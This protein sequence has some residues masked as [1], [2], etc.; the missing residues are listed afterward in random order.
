MLGSLMKVAL[1]FQKQYKPG[2]LSI[3]S[4][5]SRGMASL[6]DEL[7]PIIFDFA[8]RAQGRIGSKQANSLSRVSRRFRNIALAERSL[9]TTLRSNASKE[10]LQTFISRSGADLDFQVFVDV[11]PEW[12]LKNRDAFWDELR[13]TASRWKTL[14]VAE[15]VGRLREDG[16]PCFQLYEFFRA[17]EGMQLLRLQELFIKAEDCET[18]YRIPIAWT[19][20]N[21]RSLRCSN[22]TPL[23][24]SSTVFSSVTTCSLSLELSE[25]E[26]HFNSA[27]A[28]LKSLLFLPS[29]TDMELEL[30]HVADIGFAEYQHFQQLFTLLSHR[31]IFDFRDSTCRRA[32]GTLPHRSF[33]PCICLT[34]KSFRSLSASG[35]WG[36]VKSNAP[37]SSPNCRSRCSLPTFQILGLAFHLS[38]TSSHT[39][40]SQ[41][42]FTT[43]AHELR[44]RCSQE[45]FPFPSIGFPLS[46]T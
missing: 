22:Y 41:K 31:S 21:L 42:T 5:L 44:S 6:P 25:S 26:G 10:E 11:I 9:W 46:R 4:K 17:F 12:S 36:K 2:V 13:P 8:V 28:L 45:Y 20:P 19:S 23:A 30:R 43:E 7:L 40:Q 16:E 34:L 15:H 39:T 18:F 24:S 38:S 14:S 32:S 35:A 37:N 3:I 27:K 29:V 1:S 33:R